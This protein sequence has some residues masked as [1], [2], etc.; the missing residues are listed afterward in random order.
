MNQGAKKIFRIIEIARGGAQ[1]A[2]WE[3]RRQG[4]RERGERR[5]CLHVAMDDLARV[6]ILD[7]LQE[8]INDETLVD[9]LKNIGA[10]D[11]VKVSL[12]EGRKKEQRGRRT[13]TK[14]STKFQRGQQATRFG[15]GE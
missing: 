3:E 1:R 14:D 8:L 13:G 10:D 15:I 5:K 2:K 6:H 12:C 11:S 4:A 9:V 7:G